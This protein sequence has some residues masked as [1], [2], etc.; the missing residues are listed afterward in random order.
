MNAPSFTL[1]TWGKICPSS[2]CDT[3]GDVW[4]WGAADLISE[5]KDTGSADT[6]PLM[7]Q[8]SWLL[9]FNVIGYCQIPV[10][11]FLKP[12]IKNKENAYS[13]FPYCHFCFHHYFLSHSSL[14]HSKKATSS[15]LPSCYF[16]QA[17]VVRYQHTVFFYFS[18][19]LPHWCSFIWGKYL[20]FTHF[21]E[22]MWI[23]RWGENKSV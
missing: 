12:E 3:L 1:G 6:S 9:T 20:S 15:T 7:M 8:S 14:I 10:V 4:S 16:G 22:C 17:V 2:R 5:S 23:E 18:P 19:N 13:Q 11:E 21:Q